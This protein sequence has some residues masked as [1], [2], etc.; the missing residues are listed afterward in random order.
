MPFTARLASVAAA[1]LIATATNAHGQGFDAFVGVGGGALTRPAKS[2]LAFALTLDHMR[3]TGGGVHGAI[4]LSPIGDT[5]L[6]SG[7]IR[8][9]GTDAAL[10]VGWS[11]LQTRRQSASLRASV[12]VFGSLLYSSSETTDGRRVAAGRWSSSD[13]GGFVRLGGRLRVADRISV[14]AEGVLRVSA[15]SSRMVGPGVVAGL[16]VG[17]GRRR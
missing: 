10:L 12:G 3:A 7:G 8:E 14:G 15:I 5:G 9:E 6:A 2:S 16:S 11:V 13:G 1:V 17:L 4:Y